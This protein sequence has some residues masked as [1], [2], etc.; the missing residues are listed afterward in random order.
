MSTT[1][2][3]PTSEWGGEAFE[4][5]EAGLRRAGHTA[6][7]GLSVWETLVAK[8][9]VGF[10]FVDTDLRVVRVNERLAQ[11]SGSTVADLLG[12]TV[13][14]IVPDLWSTLEPL[15]HDVLDCGEAVV[16]VEVNGLSP[17]DP[18]ASCCWL[19]SCYPVC[20][21]GLVIGIGVV[22]VDISCRKEAERAVRFQADLLAAVGQAVI[23]TDPEGVVV[24]W[25]RAAEDLYGWSAVDAI[26]RGVGELI[27][28][29]ET[30]ERGEAILDG[31]RRGQSW[32]G[33][34]WVKKRDG[35]RFP[36]AVT[37]S[38]VFD[39]DGVLEAIIAVSADATERRAA[40]VLRR[41]HLAIVDGSGDA[42]FG[43]SNDGLIT[44]WNAAAERLFGY[45]ADEIVGRSIVILAS[46]DTVAAQAE[47]RCRV[48]AGGAAER[49]EATR[50][51]K[52]GTMVEVLMSVAPVV[53]DLQRVSGLSV[54]AH[55]ISEQRSARRGQA[56][57]LHQLGEA[58]RLNHFGSCEVDLITGAV[59]RSDEYY[60]ILGLNAGQ[61]FSS[62]Q[63]VSMVHPDDR[64]GAARA[65]ADAAERGFPIDIVYRIIR[66]DSVQRWV[67]ISAVPQLDRDG[68]VIILPITLVDETERVDAERARKSA[69]S[70]FEIGFEQSA[71]GAV[72]A[73][74]D[75][76]PLRV[77]KAVMAML[78]RTEDQLVGHLWT[79][80][81]HP[82]DVV[83]DES[84]RDRMVLDRMASGHD[85]FED[86]RRYLRPDATVVWA[87]CQVT[88][89]RD[90]VGQ[91]D[92]LFAQFQDITERKKMA[93]ALVHET[94]HDS[95]T[96]LPNRALLTDRLLHRLQSERQRGTHLAAIFLNIDY[97]N[98]INDSLGHAAGDVVLRHA[99]D[100]I[101]AAVRPGD[102]VARFG[103][104]EFVVVCDNVTVVE[105]EQIAERVLDALSQ[106]CQIGDQQA[107]VT[108][109]VGIALADQHST[110]ETM[111]RDSGAAMLRAKRR[112]QAPIELFDKALRL[113]A[114][115]RFA[116]A[117]ALKHALERNEFTIH[118]QPVVNLSTGAMDS[119]EA[120]VRWEHPE[121]GLVPPSDFIPLAEQIG[122]IMPLGAWV[123]EQACQQLVQWRH[124]APAMTV[125]VNVSV[126]QILTPG[127]TSLVEDVLRRTGAPA[128]N[129]CLELTESV[130]MGD[131]DYFATSL[132]SLKALGVQLSIDDF[133]TGYSALSYLK[134]YPIDAVKIDQSF[135]AGLGTDTHDTALVAAIIAMAAALD[136]EV[137][138]EGVETEDQLA[139][140]K[141]LNCERAQGYYFARPMPAA[142]IN[143]LVA[144]THHWRVG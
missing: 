81:A 50:R 115:Q 110:T 77:N 13:A 85:T 100:R 69:E 98:E 7:D 18:L 36:V 82:D 89:V 21:D 47:V 41:Q 61:Q 135:I 65:W 45:S 113:K 57:S 22:V 108:A 26:G 129:L 141:K 144:D 109:S 8:A 56:T 101:S 48:I 80:F 34:Y 105:A 130:F 37:D 78:G 116:T 117:A 134:Q 43:V 2:A 123:L 46:A 6:V 137:I 63:F 49:Y 127:F 118:Y 103:G 121:R 24:Y 106:P 3:F 52:D 76:M 20:A 16:D 59:T 126:R 55:D 95:L 10:G 97:F 99:A 53:D 122:L 107:S 138:A 84:V 44:T 79:D 31:L 74:L 94:L 133:G 25:N 96:G 27:S 67:R 73:G 29:G 40:D 140:L 111:L 102:T 119:A 38:P 64:P 132:N 114:E 30:I 58:Q 42:I 54:T 19:V 51:R 12:R 14:A 90:E 92:Y 62:E 28:T 104:D 91:P 17:A 128:A 125:A 136:L 32:S 71:I 60:R 66:P 112:G 131:V 75:G 143:Q 93:E 23:A 83:L 35:T 68:T 142:A 39:K 4:R 87:S 15:F 9:P 1:S 5:L 88:L 70:R 86:E 33:Q 139:D 120:L 72:I 11:I 124:T